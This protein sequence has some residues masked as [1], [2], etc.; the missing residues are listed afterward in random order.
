[1]CHAQGRAL[2]LTHISQ[3]H[4]FSEK[5]R[6][7]SKRSRLFSR[8]KHLPRMFSREVPAKLVNKWHIGNTCQKAPK[9]VGKGEVG[10]L[11]VFVTQTLRTM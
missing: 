5:I 4:V 9:V 1:M 7:K 6:I 3:I 11:S 8:K 2:T 10:P